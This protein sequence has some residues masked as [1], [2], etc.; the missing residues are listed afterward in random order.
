MKVVEIV[1]IGR[2]LLKVLSENGIKLSDYKYIDAYTDYVNMRQNRV[3]H[4]S[5]IRMLADEKHV[6]V[7][8]LERVF[9]RL[10]KV[11]K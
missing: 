11:V 7:R 5:A 3:K 2:E 10:S 1:R 6:S 9:N 4:R 8:T